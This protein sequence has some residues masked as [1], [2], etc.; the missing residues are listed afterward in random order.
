MTEKDLSPGEDPAELVFE[1]G[2][3]DKSEFC[4]SLETAAEAEAAAQAEASFTVGWQEEASPEL[5]GRG[6][7]IFKTLAAACLPT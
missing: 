6:G 2:E 4:S 1:R 7:A 5:S 3:I